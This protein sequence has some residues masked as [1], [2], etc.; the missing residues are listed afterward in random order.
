MALKTMALA[1]IEVIQEIGWIALTPL[2][3]AGF[4]APSWGAISNAGMK[5]AI[6]SS[7]GT[8]VIRK[9]RKPQPTTASGLRPISRKPAPSAC[10]IENSGIA[11]A[12]LCAPRA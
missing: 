11:L 6:S 10:E 7:I 1:A 4:R 5:A 8:T 3:A 12:P 2:S 9:W